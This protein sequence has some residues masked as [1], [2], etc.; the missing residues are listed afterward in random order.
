MHIS[1]CPP[2]YAILSL[3]SHA[4]CAVALSR[5][6]AR[7]IGGGVLLVPCGKDN[8]NASTDGGGEDQTSERNGVSFK[9]CD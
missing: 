9:K 3:E 7:G 2:T 8:A 1:I 6:V 4:R 5:G